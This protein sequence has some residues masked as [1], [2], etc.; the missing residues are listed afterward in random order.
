M[1][2]ALPYV[3]FVWM[4]SSEE[5]AQDDL[6]P[7]EEIYRR[8]SADVYRFCLYQMRG[9]SGAED[10]AAETFVSAFKAYEKARPSSESVR[11]WLI[12]IAR[13]A[14]IDNH[15]RATRRRV[16]MNL[17]MQDQS[18]DNGEPEAL[19]NVNDELQAAFEKMKALSRRDCELIALR[20][21]ADLS[22]EEI[23]QQIGLS[24]K[25]A[26]TATY[27]ALGRLRALVEQKSGEAR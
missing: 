12:R 1:H 6:A 27:R 4:A 11:F 15:R 25:S 16:F 3:L 21:G 10:V 18:R 23:G 17:L 2:P 5:A 26:Q 20:C 8:H 7:F 22:F 14:V 13:N 24:P 19:A 9:D